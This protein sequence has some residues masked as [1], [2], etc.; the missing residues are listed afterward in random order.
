M[1]YNKIHLK[2]IS[3]SLYLSLMDK[4]FFNY[5]ENNQNGNERNNQ[6]RNYNQNYRRDNNINR[7]RMV[8]FNTRRI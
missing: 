8:G 2:T 3:F 4:L 7:V 1:K 5:I 6:R